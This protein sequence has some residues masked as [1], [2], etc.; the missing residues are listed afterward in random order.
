MQSSQSE[1]AFVENRVQGSLCS[2]LRDVFARLQHRQ[3]LASAAKLAS[4][5]T[6]PKNDLECYVR[7]PLLMNVSKPFGRDQKSLG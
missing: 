2:C 5:V 7:V 3:G 6:F 1:A 4:C